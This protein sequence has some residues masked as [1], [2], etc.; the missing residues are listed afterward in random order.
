VAL[1]STGNMG[2]SV[3]AYAAFAG[4]ECKVFI[5]DIVGKEKIT[6]MKAYGAETIAVDGDYSVAMKQAKNL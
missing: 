5:P 1:A 2:A 3:A 4:M 6:Q